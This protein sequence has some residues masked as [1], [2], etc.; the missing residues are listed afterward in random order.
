MSRAS[1]YL[2]MPIPILMGMV[3]LLTA[4]P[5]SL[6][7]M[8]EACTAPVTLTSETGTFRDHDPAEAEHYLNNQVRHTH[9]LH[10]HPHLHT[11]ID[12]INLPSHPPNQYNMPSP[13]PF[14]SPIV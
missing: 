11:G 1:N 4:I 5:A 2:L 14:P 9:Q 8:H 6:A 13:S 3:L 10:L 7:Q 12:S